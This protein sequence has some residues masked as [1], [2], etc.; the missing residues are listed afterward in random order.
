MTLREVI[1]RRVRKLYMLNLASFAFFFG[2][3]F[4]VLAQNRLWPIAVFAFVAFLVA[5][6]Y[7][8]YSIRCPH[9]CG[10]IGFHITHAGA[11]FSTPSKFRFCPF[12]GVPL[13]NQ[14]DETPKT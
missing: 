12:C 4:L 11:G 14:L 2:S 3:I 5:R 6:L 10:Q 7:R 13:D 9:C 1:D 8:Y